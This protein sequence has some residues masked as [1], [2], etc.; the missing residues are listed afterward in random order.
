MKKKTNT[1]KK[2]QAVV[3]LLIVAV[4]MGFGLN[5]GLS[6]RNGGPMADGAAALEEMAQNNPTNAKA[7][8]RLGN[9]YF[10]SDQYEKSI[11]AYTRALEITPDNANVITD[12]GVMYRRAGKPD[13]AVAAFDRAIAADPVHEKSRLNKGIVML[14]DL[15]DIDGA[16]AAWEG[17]LE[18]NPY[19]MMGN[20]LSLQELVNRYK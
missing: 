5:I 2:Y 8:I 16:V 20:D 9:Y 1:K 4:S 18:L 12:M 7:W 17:L 13:Q 14:N 15:K 10:D 3:W 6:N 11:Q 19:F